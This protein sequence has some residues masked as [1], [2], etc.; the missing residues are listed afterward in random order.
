M[1]IEYDEILLKI[2]SSLDTSKIDDSIRKLGEIKSAFPMDGIKETASDMKAFADAVNSIKSETVR[3]IAS[4]KGNLSKA[5]KELQ[6]KDKMINIPVKPKIEVAK[7]EVDNAIKLPFEKAK[8]DIK[9]LDFAKQRADE[10]AKS[11][12]EVNKQLAEQESYWKNIGDLS[13]KAVE[14]SHSQRASSLKGQITKGRTEDLEGT[15]TSSASAW[16]ATSDAVDK[17]VRNLEYYKNLV[18]EIHQAEATKQYKAEM[19]A[20]AEEWNEIGN[21]I[22]GD[23]SKTFEYQGAWYGVKETLKEVGNTILN[24]ISN[25]DATYEQRVALEMAKLEAEETAES[26]K[27][28]GTEAKKSLSPIQKLAN[29]FKNFLQYRA[30]RAV[31]SAFTQGAKE[32]VKNLEGWD[33]TIGHTGFA[34]SMDRART[35][36]T[37]LKN[38]LAVIVAPGLEWLIGILREV[39]SWAVLCANA[40]SRF[41]AI[42]GGKS[43]YRA[44]KSIDSIASSESK[45]GGS[46]KKAT[47]EFKKQLMAFDEINNITEQNTGGGGGG[48]GA[49][50]GGGISDMFENL[51][52][53]KM[54][55]LEQWV[56]KFARKWGSVYEEN[57]RAYMDAEAKWQAIKDGWYNT[58]EET[59]RSYMD[60]EKKWENI[61]SG[62]V[63]FSKSL[64]DGLK[65]FFGAIWKSISD[66]AKNDWQKMKTDWE[67]IWKLMKS[68]CEP[69]VQGLKDGMSSFVLHVKAGMEKV[70]AYIEFGATTA[71]LMWD[72]LSGKKNLAEFKA[73]MEEAKNV[74]E[75]KVKK[76][77]DDLRNALENTFNRKWYV[78]T[79][80]DE[81]INRTVHVNEVYTA[82]GSKGMRTVEKY[83]EGGVVPQ[84]QLFIAR[85]AGAELVGQVGGHTAVMN[86]QDIVG[87]VSQGV[88]SAVASV[89]GNGT[90]VSVT[91]EGDAKGLFK[92]VQREGRA[93]SART[94]QP[95]LA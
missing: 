10:E 86:N 20:V 59:T 35:S 19:D 72:V 85:E 61:T 44:V 32:G 2:G 30:M 28:I 70:K 17:T 62:F 57:T 76:A 46:A 82:I 41:M 78:K 31:W 87:A 66:T 36:L 58:Y 18:N 40:I 39:A 29:K 55:A 11:L 92:V 53:G 50:V 68:V 23:I 45:A 38:S 73:G 81:I 90:N 91:L 25:P 22:D 9:M 75:G 60:A 24:A 3:A 48:G 88:A 7:K 42:L 80:W 13:N 67:N 77:T 95:A 47:A 12:A 54:N 94:G 14:S 84:G 64:W 4:L 6:M 27:R 56:D 69:V 89:M 79:V 15:Y 8:P 37:M 63:T 16:E 5:V 1:A 34:E 33:R 51:D 49:S 83:A 93:Y 43:T 52:V 26:V 65:S 71:S 74:L 21:A